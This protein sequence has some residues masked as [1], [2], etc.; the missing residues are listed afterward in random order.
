MCTICEKYLKGQIPAKIALRLVN[1]QV[2]CCENTKDRKAWEKHLL[3]LNELIMSKEVPLPEADEKA[4]AD[5]TEKYYGDK[6]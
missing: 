2:L 4:D 1:D 6:Q 3:E 5:W